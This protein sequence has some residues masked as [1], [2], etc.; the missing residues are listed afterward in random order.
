[1]K[2]QLWI[3]L[4]DECAAASITGGCAVDLAG[5]KAAVSQF[6]LHVAHVV[7]R[8]NCFDECKPDRDRE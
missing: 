4:G 1:M 3:F 6:H 5:V 7:I 2:L 8:R